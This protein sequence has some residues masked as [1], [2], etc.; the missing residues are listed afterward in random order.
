MGK[1]FLNKEHNPD[2][3]T[4]DQSL[5]VEGLLPDDQRSEHTKHTLRRAPNPTEGVR[6]IE[7][8]KTGGTVAATPTIKGGGP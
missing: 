2:C 7:P 5:E 3:I 4:N 8:G 1:P 6:H